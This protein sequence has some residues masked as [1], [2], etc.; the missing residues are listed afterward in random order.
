MRRIAGLLTTLT[1]VAALAAPA[2]AQFSVPTPPWLP[3]LLD[4]SASAA[5]AAYD[6][7]PELG[8]VSAPS[9]STE[10][11]QTLSLTGANFRDGTAVTFGDVPAAAVTMIDSRQLTVVTPP[12]PAGIVELRVSTYAGPSNALPFEFVSPPPPAPPEPVASAVAPVSPA[13]CTVPKLRGLAVRAARAALADA[14]CATGQ[15]TRVRRGRRGRVTTSVPPAGTS[16]V[17]GTPVALSV[18]RG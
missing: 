12:H 17:A 18:G 9:G 4:T 7:P 10:G 5:V 15:V 6:A 2:E 11:G 14:G 8:E 1:L 16:V 3:G 13:P